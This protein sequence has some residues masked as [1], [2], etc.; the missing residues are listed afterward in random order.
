MKLSI[1]FPGQGAQFI[2]M[3]KDVAEAYPA[4]RAVFDEVDD[5]LGVKLSELMWEGERDILDLTVNAQPA[6]MTASIAVLRG[7]ECEGLERRDFAVL[8][9]HSLGEY[10]AL[11]AAGSLSLP[12]TARLLRSRGQAMQEAVPVGEGAM[13]A[14]L[15]L[16]IEEVEAIARE[17]SSVGLCEVANDNDPKQVV[18]SGQLA[19][20]ERAMRIAPGIG[21]RR[22][23]RLATSAPFH[24]SMMQPAAEKM[25]DHLAQVRFS[26]PNAAVVANVTACPVPSAGD[27]PELLVRQVTGRVRWRETML[28]MAAEGIGRA[29]ELGAGNALSGMCR[30]TVPTVSCSPCGTP[31]QLRTAI[32]QLRENRDV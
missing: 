2:G 16:G 13:A 29:F 14:I 21:A 9:G 17:A 3:G 7:L 6:L 10:T 15:G 31:A 26:E 4:A 28:W 25:K 30:R 18:V 24:C 12:T 1:L 22:A 5:A 20:V 27:I 32:Q 19:A 8:A 11:C 23:V